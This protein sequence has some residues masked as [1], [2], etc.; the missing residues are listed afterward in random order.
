MLSDRRWRHRY[1]AAEEG[2]VGLIHDRLSPVG[3]ARC[4]CYRQPLDF[5]PNGIGQ[6]L[7]GV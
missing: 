6:A 1:A 4:P 2:G 7:H 5:Q 3:G